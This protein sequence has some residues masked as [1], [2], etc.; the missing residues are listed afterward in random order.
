MSR[1]NL[2]SISVSSAAP[3]EKSP[4]FDVHPIAEEDEVGE[5]QFDVSF[6]RLASIQYPPMVPAS[7]VKNRLGALEE[8]AQSQHEFNRLTT[9]TFQNLSNNVSSLED[10]MREFVKQT[11]GE[12]EGKISLMKKENDHRFELQSNENKRLQ[13]HVASLK[14][15]NT[16]LKRK[17][18]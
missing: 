16:M 6:Q 3:E 5:T 15:D 1:I 18:V 17:L 10:M 8:S 13:S 9:K 7:S 12:I 2:P 4:L 11:Q 14:A